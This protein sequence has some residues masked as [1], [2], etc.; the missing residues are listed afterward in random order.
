MLKEGV[1]WRALGNDGVHWR[2]V[3]G[4][5]RRWLDLGVIDAMANAIDEVKARRGKLGALDSTHVKVH[6]DGA[7]PAGGQQAQAIGKSKGGNNTKIHG[8]VNEH[9]QLVA[10]SYTAGNRH[11]NTQAQAL[12]AQCTG[13]GMEE[14]IAD[15]AYDAKATRRACAEAGLQACIPSKCNSKQ[16]I[17]HNVET[18]KKRHVVEN[19]WEVLKRCRRV[20]TRYEKLILTFSG[21]VRLA[22][23]VQSLRGKL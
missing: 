19:V 1:S 20:A 10:M 2:T 17:A 22:L 21:F 6:R 13:V 14:L 8:V 7:N 18:F 11:D 15:K 5:W 23:L 16:P 9:K 4:H 3:Y 12:I